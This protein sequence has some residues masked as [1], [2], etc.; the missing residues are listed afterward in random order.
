MSLI[1][2]AAVAD[3]NVIGK[4]NKLPWH[5]PE[6]LR[7]FRKI[8]Q[9]HTV[10]MG[11]KTYE[12][13]VNRL[14]KPLPNR[15]NVVISRKIDYSVPNGVEIFSSIDEFLSKLNSKKE[16]IYI[17]G[18]ASLYKQTLPLAEFMEITHIH[19]KPSGDAYFPEVDWSRWKVI[20]R[21]DNKKFSFVTYQKIN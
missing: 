11:R 19:E 4:D 18:G 9:G 7:H 10:V 3:N 15:K 12:S 20:K 6:D 21:E 8:T 14:K 2:I 17:I 13:I 5:L 1:I 16:D